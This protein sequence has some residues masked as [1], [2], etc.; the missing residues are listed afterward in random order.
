MWRKNPITKFPLSQVL[1]LSMIATLSS[2]LYGID[3]KVDKVPVFTVVE[4]LRTHE[5][6]AVSFIDSGQRSVVSL[7]LRDATVEE[8]LSK[9]AAQSSAY[10]NENIAGRDVLYP[11]APEFQATVD[12]VDIQHQTRQEATELYVDLLRRAVP[13]FPRLVPPVLFG[14]NRM[15]VYSDKVTLRSK[16]RVIEHFVDLLGKDQSLYFKFIKARSGLPSLEF[17]RISCETALS[18]K[19]SN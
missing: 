15:P 3:I 2:A 5:C 13:A 1:T 10:R 18:R 14:D 12:N 19:T 17:E 11:T 6:A 9:I 8:V 16:G 7:N 4:Y